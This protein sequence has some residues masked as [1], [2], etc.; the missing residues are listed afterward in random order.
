MSRPAGGLIALPI[1]LTLLL[2]TVGSV[3]FGFGIKTSCTTFSENAST[4]GRVDVAVWLSLLAQLG[5]AAALGLSSVIR[6]T[7]PSV[8]TAGIAS[9]ASLGIFGGAIALAESWRWL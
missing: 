7:T 4:C 3:A 2:G 1:G 6:R 5:L 9:L 8:R